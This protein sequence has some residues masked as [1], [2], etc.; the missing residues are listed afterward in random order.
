MYGL[1]LIKTLL[2]QG[3]KN[4][5]KAFF[6]IDISIRIDILTMRKENVYIENTNIY[7][8]TLKSLPC[9]IVHLMSP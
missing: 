4:K 5:S 8:E 9:S 1:V 3:K 2:I 6:F 7:I